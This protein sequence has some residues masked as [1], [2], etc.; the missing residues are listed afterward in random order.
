MRVLTITPPLPTAGT[1]G[2]M[3]P[4]ARQ[5]AS[6]R[7]AGVE[8]DVL[9]VAGR[10]GLGYLF[11]LPRV[12]SLVRNADLVHAHYGNCGWVARSQASRPIVI[13]FMGS[14]LLGSFRRNGKRKVSGR[15]AVRANRWL[16]SRVDAVI[17]KSAQM[18]EVV[19]HVPSHVLPN[20][21]ELDEFRPLDRAQ[22]RSTLGW[23][24]DATYI[25]FPGD[26]SNPR[27]N[28]RLAKQVVQCA[29]R[30]LDR[31]LELV[32]LWD[33]A[34]QRVPLYMNACDAMLMMSLRE[35]SP[36]V[37]KEAM[38]CDLPVVSV[39]VGY[40]EEL[41]GGVNGNHVRPYDAGELAEALVAVLSDNVPSG[42]R[43]AMISRGLDL[44]GV[45]RRIINVY[46]SVLK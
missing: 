39:P 45:A 33:V 42:G 35:G 21:V 5:F 15:A 30:R 41:L 27:K 7:A 18:A 16:A 4:A 23:E 8:M 24:L 3:A 11:A 9:E 37:V 36:N 14:D 43:A 25:L 10:K 20:G 2:S 31:P 34:P 38:A 46:E 40:V 1:P 19:S 17:V 13:S 32:T 26:P 22:S 29:T 44:D 6:L 28:Y 12:R